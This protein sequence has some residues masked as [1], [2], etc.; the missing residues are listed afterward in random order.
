MKVKGFST[1][2]GEIEK[3][4]IIERS[5]FMF[6][7]RNSLFPRIIAASDTRATKYAKVTRMADSRKNIPNIPLFVLPIAL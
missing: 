4:N 2:K 6:E 3:L 1:V 7:Y 5:K